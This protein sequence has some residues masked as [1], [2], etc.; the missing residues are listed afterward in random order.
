MFFPYLIF[1]YVSYRRR[2]F[3]V[4]FSSLAH[5]SFIGCLNRNRNVNWMSIII[6]KILRG[7]ISTLKSKIYIPKYERHTWACS[8]NPCCSYEIALAVSEN[9]DLFCHRPAHISSSL[10]REYR[11]HRESSIWKGKVYLMRI[12][13]LINIWFWESIMAKNILQ[14]KNILC[15]ISHMY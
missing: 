15:Y 9:L 1:W 10:S 12:L 11:L 6:H 4:F 2:T 13:Q 8:K 14:N 3:V 5:E 7:K